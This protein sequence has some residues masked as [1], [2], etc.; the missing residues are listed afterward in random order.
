MVT[1]KQEGLHLPGEKCFFGQRG[2]EFC[3]FWIDEG[4][5]HTEQSK[6]S[7]VRD[8]PTPTKPRDVKEFLGLTGFYRKFIHHYAH[9]AMPLYQAVQSEKLEW[10]PEQEAAFCLLKKSVTEAPVLTI[11]DM[12]G[13]WTLRTDASKLAMGA[14]L[15]QAPVEG[16]DERVNR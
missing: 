11:P 2:V 4:G 5:V 7:A 8:W 14:V 15:M 6:V 10:T 1:L 13:Q 9:I 16:G 3:G 12:D